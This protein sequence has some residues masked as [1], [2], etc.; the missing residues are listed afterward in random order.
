VELCPAELDVYPPGEEDE[1]DPGE[2]HDDGSDDEQGAKHVEQAA[3]AFASLRGGQIDATEL[4]TCAVDGY[5]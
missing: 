1:R 3:R 2:T 4:D 5:N